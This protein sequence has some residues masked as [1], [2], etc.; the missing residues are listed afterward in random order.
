MS[1]SPYKVINLPSETVIHR[2]RIFERF[3]RVDKARARQASGTGLG[4]SIVEWAVAAHRGKVE[5]GNHNKSGS[6]FRVRLPKYVP[7]KQEVSR[8][9]D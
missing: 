1:G 9:D 2:T 3:Y 7:A 5:V 4:P 8:G 6:I